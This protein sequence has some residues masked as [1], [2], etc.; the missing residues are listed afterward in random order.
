[1]S[2][3]TNIPTD[4]AVAEAGSDDQLRNN[5]ASY[6]Q[7]T[8]ITMALEETPGFLSIPRINFYIIQV[9]KQE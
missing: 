1:V 7:I 2:A 8:P 4:P 5:K 9:G 6:Q 3:A